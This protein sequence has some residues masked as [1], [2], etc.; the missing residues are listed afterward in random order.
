MPALG[1]A[2]TRQ[3]DGALIEW[4][5][6]LEEQKSSFDV[7]DAWHDTSTLASAEQPATPAATPQLQQMCA[8]SQG[9]D[10]DA[11]TVIA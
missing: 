4:R 1:H 10:G 7:Q 3:L 2:A 9:W 8:D 5:L 11:L 6:E